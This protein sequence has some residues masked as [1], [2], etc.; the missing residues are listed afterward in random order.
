MA[1]VSALNFSSSLLKQYF[2]F[3]GLEKLLGI[4]VIERDFQFRLKKTAMKF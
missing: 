4:T 2:D 3:S 1:K